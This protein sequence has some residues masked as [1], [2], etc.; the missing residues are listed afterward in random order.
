M[1]RESE[2]VSQ[3]LARW[4]AGDE[5]ALQ[6]LIPSVYK[7]LHALAHY[8][9][10]A[11]RSHHTLQSTAL[12][13]EAY[14]RLVDQS[15][16]Q[17]ENRAHFVAVAARLMRQILVDYA[18]TRRAAKRGPEFKLELE[19]ALDLPDKQSVDVVALD[20]A[21]SK[22]SRRDPQQERIV[23]LRFFGGMTV[24]ETAEVLGISVATVKRDWN[25]AKAWLTREMRGGPRGTNKAVGET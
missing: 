1:P 12:V 9:L 16:V 18:R 13:N 14:L 23:E 4:R 15:P 20:D 17:A 2:P 5:K 25:M 21:L 7:E 10:K 11:E 3:L 6:A 8:C 19:E 22:L 24:E